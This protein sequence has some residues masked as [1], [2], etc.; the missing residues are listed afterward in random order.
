MYQII[1]KKGY[2]HS[3]SNGSDM[4]PTLPTTTAAALSNMLNYIRVEFSSKSTHIET[5]IFCV[6]A[7]EEGHLNVK[8]LFTSIRI[9]IKSV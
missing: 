7:P 1:L 3:S 8:M 6:A 9:P 2:R 5:F 4:H